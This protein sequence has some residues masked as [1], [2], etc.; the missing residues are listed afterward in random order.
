MPSDA[1]GTAPAKRDG[2]TVY[3]DDKRAWMTCQPLTGAYSDEQFMS[4]PCVSPS[5]YFCDEVRRLV[6]T[7]TLSAAQAPS[8]FVPDTKCEC[9]F[10]TASASCRYF[11]PTTVQNPASANPPAST[12]LSRFLPPTIRPSRSSPVPFRSTSPHSFPLL[13]DACL[14]LVSFLTHASGPFPSFLATV[15]LF[16]S[17]RL[18]TGCELQPSYNH[19]IFGAFWSR[20]Q[21]SFHLDF[22]I[23]IIP[24]ASLTDSDTTNR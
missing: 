8:P 17:I 16:L 5:L 1:P 19:R 11:R 4:A 12:V 7:G 14:I 6:P 18:D 21:S 15:S 20:L 2:G 3:V 13:H 24:S 22:Q 23:R 10:S 9:G